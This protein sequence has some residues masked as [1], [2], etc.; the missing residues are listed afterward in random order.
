MCVCVLNKKKDRWFPFVSRDPFPSFFSFKPEYVDL[1]TRIFYLKQRIGHLSHTPTLYT[2]V[3]YPVQNKKSV[4][5]AI[6]I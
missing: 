6:T 3:Y 5:L 2:R 4:Y 1:F